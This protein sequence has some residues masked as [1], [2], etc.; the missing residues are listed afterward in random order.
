M[1][2]CRVCGATPP[3]LTG[4][5]E[6]QEALVE[7]VKNAMASGALHGAEMVRSG[8]RKVDLQ[9]P[10]SEVFDGPARLFLLY[11][12]SLIELFLDLSA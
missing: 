9:A 11:R 3:E 6:R 10:F 4:T 12:P 1:S 7:L 5:T 2:A 8:G